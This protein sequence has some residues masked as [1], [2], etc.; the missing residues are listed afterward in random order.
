MHVKMNMLHRD[1]SISAA[2]TM[3]DASLG[4]TSSVEVLYLQP[5]VAGA[6]LE[7]LPAGVSQST[8]RTHNLETVGSIFCIP[9]FTFVLMS[10]NMQALN[11]Y[12]DCVSTVHIFVELL[13][14]RMLKFQ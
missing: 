4:Q 9:S 12:V 10:S 3:Y 14:L 1:A 2:S 7:C 13:N 5:F 6:K 11:R 8:L